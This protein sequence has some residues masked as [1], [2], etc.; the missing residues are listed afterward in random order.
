MVIKL[1]TGAAVSVILE[2]IF[3]KKFQSVK[4][5]PSDIVLKTYTGEKI[6]PVG[7]ADVD[8]KY[9]KQHKN[10]KLYVVR[11]AGVTRFGRGW[12]K[13]ITLNWPEIKAGK[14]CKTDEHLKFV[15]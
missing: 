9:Q 15:R 11:K 12:L 3:K 10:L 2:K 13:H 14:M 6:K 4:M 1:D 7:V 5:K 8:V